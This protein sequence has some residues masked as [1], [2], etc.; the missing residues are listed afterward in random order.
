[1]TVEN[2]DQIKQLMALCTKS[3]DEL[4]AICEGLNLNTEG[5]SAMLVDRLTSIETNAQANIGIGQTVPLRTKDDHMNTLELAKDAM[6]QWRKMIFESGGTKDFS[7]VNS[8]GK[9]YSLQM[10]YIKCSNDTLRKIIKKGWYLPL[11]Q[12]RDLID[13]V[14]DEPDRFTASIVQKPAGH[15]KSWLMLH[16]EPKQAA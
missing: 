15:G 16:L 7:L 2:A 8:K 11:D 4:R 12:Y 1:M 3:E 10:K 6:L 13:V 5:D 14:M 9:Q